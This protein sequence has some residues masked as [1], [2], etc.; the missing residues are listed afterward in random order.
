MCVTDD[1]VRTGQVTSFLK[2]KKNTRENKRD[3]IPSDRTHDEV[4][5]NA[6]VFFRLFSNKK[7]ESISTA[8]FY[9]C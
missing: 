3:E 6:Y 1:H 5:G 7:P 8:K 9:I 4:I 2:K